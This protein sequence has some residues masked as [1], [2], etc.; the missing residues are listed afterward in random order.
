VWG[1]DYLAIEGKSVEPQGNVPLIDQTG[2][3]TRQVLSILSL[4]HRAGLEPG[5][6]DHHRHLTDVS[7][8]LQLDLVFANAG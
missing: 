3:V 8:G 5:G 4:R 6:I 2:S 1:R 7:Y